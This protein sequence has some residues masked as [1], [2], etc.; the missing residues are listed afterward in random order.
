MDLDL[1]RVWE[2][3]AERIRRAALMLC[4]NPWDAD[5]LAQE[6]F[7]VLADNPARFAGRSRLSTWLYGVLLNLEATGGDSVLSVTATQL[8]RVDLLQSSN[9]TLVEPA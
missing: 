6:T 9:V 3:H 5:D 2:E 7:L 1:G 4:G 8:L